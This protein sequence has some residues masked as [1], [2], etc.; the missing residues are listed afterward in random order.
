MELCTLSRTANPATDR[1]EEGIML[2]DGTGSITYLGDRAAELLNQSRERVHDATLADLLRHGTEKKS[3]VME[4]MHMEGELLC[5]FPRSD[6]D[7]AP[8]QIRFHRVASDDATERYIGVVRNID[9][10]D[11]VEQHLTRQLRREQLF[12][13]SISH[14]FFNPLCI[15]QGYLQL[16]LNREDPGDQESMLR[17]A[18]QAL[19]RI[20]TV[21]KNVVYDG[22]LKE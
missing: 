11:A 18:Q 16:V 14:H 12:K 8:V 6:D 5:H 20:E 17:A 15:A 2:L 21:V 19:A 7:T 10:A 1:V 22:D 13:E 4:A 3:D 9:A